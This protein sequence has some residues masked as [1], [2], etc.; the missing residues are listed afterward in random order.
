MD[1]ANRI[2]SLLSYAVKQRSLANATVALCFH[3]T[4]PHDKEKRVKETKQK[5]LQFRLVVFLLPHLYASQ[6]RPR[7]TVHLVVQELKNGVLGVS[8]LPFF[9]SLRVTPRGD[10]NVHVR[11]LG[12]PLQ[13]GILVVVVA[14]LAVTHTQGEYSNVVVLVS[15]ER[16]EHDAGNTAIR[17]FEVA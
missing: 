13:G 17:R 6:P 11:S 14:L 8:N 4:T 16:G 10:R 5:G 12:E 1:T 7:Q 2:R 3:T 15:V 9:G